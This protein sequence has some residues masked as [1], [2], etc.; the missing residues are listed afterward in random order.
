ME[1]AETTLELDRGLKSRVYAR[2]A[3]PAFW[4]VNLPE[5]WVE[6]QTDPTGPDESPGYRSCHIIDGTGLLPLVLDGRE[7]ARIAAADILPL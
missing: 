3:I 7:V 6:V 4:I 2:A 5:G 1:V